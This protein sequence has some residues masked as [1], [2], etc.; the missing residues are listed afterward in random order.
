MAD[1]DRQETGKK[2]KAR[3]GRPT[4]RERRFEGVSSRPRLLTFA[5]ALVGGLALGA[6]V[7]GQWMSQ[8]PVTYAPWLVGAAV[9]V[10]GAVLVLGDFGGGFVRVGDGGVALERGGKPLERL[11][12]HAVRSVELRDGLLEV[13]G[14]GASISLRLDTH[15]AAAAW[16]V[17][18]AE[19]RVPKAVRV[20]GEARRALPERRETDGQVVPIEKVQV[21][22]ARSR[23][24]DR[25]ITFER[26]A[27][28]CPRCGELYHREDVPG[29]CLTCEGDLSSLKDG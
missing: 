6:G 22:G 25:I 3:K 13:R 8:R 27:R 23:A 12:W 19:S 20:S 26:D 16:L 18:E 14:E 28:F 29:T 5:G 1:S 4:M 9:V 7:F 21:T 2:G 11:A 15:P 10:L 17:H 24:S